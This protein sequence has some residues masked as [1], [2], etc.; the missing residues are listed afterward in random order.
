MPR[1]LSTHSVYLVDGIRTPFLIKPTRPVSYSPLD[2]S[3]ISS[4]TLL[5]RQPFMAQDIDAVIIGSSLTQPT[6]LA[7]KLKQ[8]LMP[9][10]SSQPGSTNATSSQQATLSLSGELSG[11]EALEYACQQIALNQ[12]Q[13]VLTGGVDMLEITPPSTLPHL[14]TAPALASLSQKLLDKSQ[15]LGDLAAK[16]SPKEPAVE[17]CSI[18]RK[19]AEKK[20]V[21]LDLSSQ[22][23]TDY[24][25]LSQRRLQYA[26]RNNLLASVMPVFYPDGQVIYRDQGISYNDAAQYDTANNAASHE[27]R[28]P[29]NAIAPP[30]EGASF[31]LLA[32]KTCVQ[33]HQL[34]VIAEL[35]FT[36]WACGANASHQK[37]VNQAVKELLNHAKLTLKD[38]DYW[39]INEHSAVD[40]LAAQQ[41]CKHIETLA[42][43]NQVNLDGGVLTL[44]NPPAANAMRL[45]LQLAHTLKRQ[46]ASKGVVTSTFPDGRAF[47][48]LI[49]SSQPGEKQ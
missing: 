23:L 4:R 49:K 1:R 24:I 34:P 27:T 3:V 31:L 7:F 16:Y 36:N 9:Q 11:F 14:Q 35:S 25:Q 46:Q 40:I 41:S 45:V 26:Q 48:L 17:A 30:A 19:T 2:L 10:S 5:L 43:L 15:R 12:K 6:D 20:A 33:R 44:G 38:I 18:L 28:L 29:H 39:E 13:L 8:R 22:A 32:S 47:A 42:T 21:T 37:T